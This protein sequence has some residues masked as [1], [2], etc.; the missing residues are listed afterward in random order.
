MGVFLIFLYVVVE[1]NQVGVFVLD[2][3]YFKLEG[4]WLVGV[5]LLVEDV[6]RVLVCADELDF[7]AFDFEGGGV[8]LGEVCV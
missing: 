3:W 4:C 7:R 8:G 1:D 2:L 6:M 5:N